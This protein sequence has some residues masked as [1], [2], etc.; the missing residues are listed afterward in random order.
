MG[1]RSSSKWCGCC[2]AG[3]AGIWA[4]DG[5]DY[6]DWPGE[7]SMDGIVFTESPVGN[8]YTEVTADWS[9]S[10]ELEEMNPYP[11]LYTWIGKNNQGHNLDF[12]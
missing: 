3:V 10:L 11:F 12:L 7:D 9:A 4:D 2:L 6:S 1:S 5:V 8:S